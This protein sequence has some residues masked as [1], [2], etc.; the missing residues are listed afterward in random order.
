MN[1][2]A[3][4]RKTSK[5]SKAVAIPGSGH[6]HPILSFDRNSKQAVLPETIQV[7]TPFEVDDDYDGTQFVFDCD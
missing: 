6:T 5:E 2:H 1:A 7:M 3:R 4:S